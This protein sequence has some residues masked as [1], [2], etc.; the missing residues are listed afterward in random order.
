M[1]KT[2]E[3]SILL[4]NLIVLFVAFFWLHPVMAGNNLKKLVINDILAMACAIF[5]AGYLYWDSQIK[6]NMLIFETNWWIFCIV[7]YMVIE[8]PF[9][10]YYIKKH[11]IKF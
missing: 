9:T 11:D 10:T 7:T 5:V 6:F 8:I 2:P 1:I 4:I 3:I